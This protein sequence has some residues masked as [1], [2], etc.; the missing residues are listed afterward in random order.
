MRRD[1][2]ITFR[3][4]LKILGRDDPGWLK[5][6]D[7]LLG[8][9]ILGAGP[10]AFVS[11][12]FEAIWGMVDQKSEAVTRL[13]EVMGAFT[14]RVT[15][16]SGL[17]RQ[18]LVVAAHS[19][20]VLAAFCEAVASAVGVT[21]TEQEK[22]KITDLRRAE[23][24]GLVEALYSSSIPTPSAAASFERNVDDL[25]EWAASLS[26]KVLDVYGIRGDWTRVARHIR[27]DFAAR[28]RSH[29]LDLAAG[30]PEFGVWADQVAHAN[31]ARGLAG[32]TD[33]LGRRLAVVKDARALLDQANRSGLVRP[34]VDAADPIAVFPAIEQIFQTPRY[35]LTVHGTNTT[36]SSE[37]WWKSLPVHDDLP[38]MLARHFT[39]PDAHTRPLL[40]LGHPGAGKSVLMTALAAMLPAADYT[41]VRVRLR[42]IDAGALVAAQVA[43]ALDEATNNRVA[44]ADLDDAA[45]RVV[46]LDGLDELLQTTAADRTGYLRDVEQFQRTEAAMGQPV[47]VVVTSRTLVADRVTVRH[48]TPVV[49][50]EEFDDSQVTA[51]L[52]V[53]NSLNAR[54][55]PVASALALPEFARQPLLLLMLAIYHAEP[56]APALDAGMSLADLYE[57]LFTGFAER[58]IERSGSGTVDELLWRLSVAAIGML[59]RGAQY[60]SEA[61]LAADLAAL[62]D[63]SPTGGQVLTQFFFVH[64]PE[65]TTARGSVRGYEFLHA[66]FGE[67]LV[68]HRVVELL[69]DMTDSSFGRR[70][71]HDP[72]DELLF[73]LLSHQPLAVQRPVI[74]FIAEHL[75]RLD[76]GERGRVERT[77]DHLL[78]D[79][80]AQ[81][82]SSRYPGYCPDSTDYVA[83]LAAYSANLVLLRVLLTDVVDIES[84]WTRTGW[85]AVVRL[86]TAG[87][88]KQG[89]AAVLRLLARDGTDLVVKRDGRLSTDLLAVELTFDRSATHRMRIGVA[90]LDGV[91]V[92]DG[93]AD[94]EEIR[95]YVLGK[96]VYYLSRSTGPF[97]IEALP[98]LHRDM[99]VL[100]E[101]MLVMCGPSWSAEFARD[102]LLW[103]EATGAAPLCRAVVALAHPHLGL[104]VSTTPERF[105]RQARAY[106]ELQGAD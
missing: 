96:L 33:L 14:G 55:L 39:S 9:V 21:P 89:L 98:R 61:D 5:A 34:V 8:G 13:H 23:G 102:F 1:P 6:V 31:L 50:I 3:G 76:D 57:K 48:G 46:L 67:Y 24:Q 79:H 45:V 77:L 53:W 44:W 56:H 11:E 43:Q 83:R 93:S 65:A 2:P 30:V 66:T 4:A 10:L 105:L 20:I 80:R 58:E 35:R 16:T 19:T 99:A 18:D 73:T 92:A 95:V 104:D 84:L 12:T 32:L 97:D 72:D 41:V 91:H 103:L 71:V 38:V 40:L 49:K 69:R 25:D 78:R 29:F 81:R 88:D 101:H 74:D 82:R 47:A 27:D 17:Y 90:F 62:N 106:L 63:R 36:I 22:A 100:A 59:N 26:T 85:T 75:A 52:S 28:Y 86:W 15:G 64:S 60:V 54:P 51:W 37:A 87:L 70:A 7:R 94:D 42:H 68:A